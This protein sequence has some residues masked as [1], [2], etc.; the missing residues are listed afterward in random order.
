[1]VLINKLKVVCHTFAQKICDF[2]SYIDSKVRSQ[3][4][5]LVRIFKQENN[6]YSQNLIAI[7]R[8]VKR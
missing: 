1:M 5:L 8:A 2:T 6:L 3:H 4:V 7:G